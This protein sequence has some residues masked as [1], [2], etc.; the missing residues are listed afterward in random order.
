MISEAFEGIFHVVTTI[1]KSICDA[2]AYFF[3][4]FLQPVIDGIKVVTNAFDKM[5]EVIHHVK[6]VF[7]PVEW[8][9]DAIEWIFEVFVQPI[10]DDIMDVS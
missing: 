4:H 7:A 9:L 8:L 6:D 10:I 3:T 1:L 5:G 2:I